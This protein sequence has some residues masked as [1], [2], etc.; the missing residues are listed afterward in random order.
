MAARYGY[1]TTSVNIAMWTWMG[2]YG[3]FGNA[4][5]SDALSVPGRNSTIPPLNVLLNL[6]INSSHWRT[7]LTIESL[8][9]SMDMVI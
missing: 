3:H 7:K 1:M 6:D 5:G 4:L 9:C 2:Y 8:H